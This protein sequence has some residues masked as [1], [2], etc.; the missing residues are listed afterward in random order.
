MDGGF[1]VRFDVGTMSPK[2]LP[3]PPYQP[4]AGLIGIYIDI[5]LFHVLV[6]H[7]RYASPADLGMRPG[8]NNL[9]ETCFYD[10]SQHLLRPG[11]QLARVT[12]DQVFP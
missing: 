4:L 11:G 6:N 7:K 8:A 2:K 9:S 5:I 3:N 12:S 1:D 10:I